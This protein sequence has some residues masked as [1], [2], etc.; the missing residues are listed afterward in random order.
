MSKNLVEYTVTFL[1][2][3]LKEVTGRKNNNITVLWQAIF[4]VPLS[5][6]KSALQ[7]KVK[8][9]QAAE[10]PGF[11]KCSYSHACE[12]V[13]NH[14]SLLEILH[15]FATKHHRRSAGRWMVIN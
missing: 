7:S 3:C 15:G 9:T 14:V 2:I 11:C 10:H 13:A 8:P 1:L 6:K 4:P 12:R 5:R